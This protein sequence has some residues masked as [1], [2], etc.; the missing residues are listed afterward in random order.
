MLMVIFSDILPTA[1]SM[2]LRHI[3]HTKSIMIDIYC[4]T[5]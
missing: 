2:L 5:Y 4:Y 1:H 3:D